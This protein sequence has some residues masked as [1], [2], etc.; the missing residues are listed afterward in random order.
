[1]VR[2]TE[3]T[4]NSSHGTRRSQLLNAGLTQVKRKQK[5]HGKTLALSYSKKP[6]NINLNRSARKTYTLPSKNKK[7]QRPKK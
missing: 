7:T 3:D 5:I 1:M 4:R 6:S 2:I